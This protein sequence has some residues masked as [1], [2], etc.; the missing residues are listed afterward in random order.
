ML[1]LSHVRAWVAASVLLVA[2]VVVAS[3]DPSVSLP[4]VE[5]VDK[6]AHALAYAVLALWFGG[7]Y[8]RARYLRV[9]L[10]LCAL[11]LGLEILQHL[12]GRGRTGDPYDMAANLAGIVIGLLLG[13]WRT[14]GWA[15]RLEAWLARS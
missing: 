13:A 15:A 10:A 5:N 11:G 4:S 1:P 8:P 2:A 3:L 14:G 9:A 6:F 12:M 7:L